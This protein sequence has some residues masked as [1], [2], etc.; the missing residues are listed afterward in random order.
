MA[1]KDFLHQ[2]HLKLMG[3]KPTKTLLGK[4]KEG[5]ENSEK[6]ICSG[7]RQTK[8]NNMGLDCVMCKVE[9]KGQTI[10]KRG[11]TFVHNGRVKSKFY[12]K[13]CNCA[14]HPGDCW[15]KWH[16]KHTIEPKLEIV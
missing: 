6:T 16:A 7:E 8:F 11:R 14:I 9:K 2:I 12:C 13:G 15:E 1:R 10:T 3:P 5:D 4:R